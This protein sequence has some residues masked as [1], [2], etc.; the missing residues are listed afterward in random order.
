MPFSLSL[1]AVYLALTLLSTTAQHS[2]SVSSI[3]G[4]GSTLAA[5]GYL[6]AESRPSQLAF[7]LRL[8]P[9]KYALSCTLPYKSETHN[10]YSVAVARQPSANGTVQFAFIGWDT[11]T[12]IPFIGSLTYTGVSATD[13]VANTLMTS[14]TV[15]PCDGWQKDNYKVHMFT[16]FLIPADTAELHEDP[17]ALVVEY[18]IYVLHL[19]SSDANEHAHLLSQA[20]RSIRVCLQQPL[21]DHL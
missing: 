21:D 7:F 2:S 19:H 20:Q 11:K 1:S 17:F 18:V 13:F 8:A 16:D 4:Y 10:V 6:T 14:R 12:E 5:N 9:Y 15:F 3:D